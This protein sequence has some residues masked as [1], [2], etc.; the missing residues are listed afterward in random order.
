M[1][2]DIFVPSFVFAAEN[3]E[4]DLTYYKQTCVQAASSGFSAKVDQV[5]IVDSEHIRISYDLYINGE[6]KEEL[7]GH[8]LIT[9]KDGKIV[10]ME[11]DSSKED[12]NAYFARVRQY[13]PEE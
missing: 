13:L 9:A 3:K 12:N 7:K 2:D 1:I 11:P 4:R 5:D 10:R 8:R 6:L